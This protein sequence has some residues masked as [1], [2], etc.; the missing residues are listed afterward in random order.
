M[1]LD[2]IEARPK[3]WLHTTG[4]VLFSVVG[5]AS[6]IVFSWATIGFGPVFLGVLF[7]ASSL[8]IGW[9]V[10]GMVIGGLM[11]IGG[12]YRELI[13]QDDGIIPDQEGDNG[14]E[15]NSNQE[16]ILKQCLSKLESAKTLLF[17]SSSSSS[18]SSY[19]KDKYK[20]K[21][22]ELERDISFALQQKRGNY[23]DLRDSACD[24]LKTSNSLVVSNEFMDKYIDDV[25]DSAAEK[26]IITKTTPL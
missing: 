16:T 10:A 7:A 22:L 9:G 17:S 21:I 2:V 6:F 15:F 14:A 20:E 19:I 11:A 3:G 25:N 1:G 13:H 4:W 12:F 23:C 18:S 8:P 5:V 24:F 26:P